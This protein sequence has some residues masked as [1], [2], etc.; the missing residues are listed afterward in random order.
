[1]KFGLKDETFDNVISVLAAHPEIEKAVIYGSRAKGNYKNGSDIDLTLY[2]EALDFSLLSRI[3]SELYDLPIPHEV[4]L[5]IFTDIKNPDL[6][7]HI[8]RV[9]QVFY[10]KP[11]KS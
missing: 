10:E 8:R 6:V 9:G 5:S 11:A 2:G 3:S 1:M 4:D 7:D